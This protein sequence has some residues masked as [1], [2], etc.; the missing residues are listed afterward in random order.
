M[1]RFSV[2]KFRPPKDNQYIVIYIIPKASCQWSYI[3]ET[4]RSFST[5]GLFKARLS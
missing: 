2:P 3:G 5:A 4:K 1:K